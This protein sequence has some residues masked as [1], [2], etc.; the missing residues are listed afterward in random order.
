MPNFIKCLTYVNK[1]HGAVTFVCRSLL[2]LCISLCTCCTVLCFGRNPNWCEGMA[3]FAA[4]IGV[5]LFS[6][7]FYKI[8]D[9]SG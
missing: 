1:C 3:L 8:L 9:S 7:N 5:S 2:M 4:N 6:I